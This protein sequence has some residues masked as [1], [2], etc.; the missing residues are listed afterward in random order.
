MNY[1]DKFY[2]Q[3]VSTHT[4]SLY[5]AE[6]LESIRERFFAW[7]KYFGEFLPKDS[8]ARILDLGCGSGSLVYWLHEMG[9]RNAEGIDVS[10]EQ[11][12]QASTLG[13]KH[14]RRG[15]VSEFLKANVGIYDA[16]FAQDL[17]EHLTKP[18][19]L[20]IAESVHKSLKENGVFIIQTLNAENLLWGR[21]RWGDFTHETAFTKSGIG[22]VLRVSGF[23][24]IE[25]HPQRP[26]VHGLKSLARYVVWRVFELIM[27]AYL[28]VET[29]SSHGIFTQNLIVAAHK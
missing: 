9:F 1:Q 7:K 16:I 17:M 8:N 19:I 11:V 18:E 25:V 20:D 28:I 2:A 3:Y 26:V 29:G 5:G 10:G 13:I 23:R 12:A 6:S 15:N 24:A 4:L 14:I 27:H 21:L 22:Q